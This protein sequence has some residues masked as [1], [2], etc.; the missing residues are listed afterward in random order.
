MW[1]VDLM[2]VVFAVKNKYCKKLHVLFLYYFYIFHCSRS[3]L[4]FDNSTGDNE[5]TKDMALQIGV[6][7]AA[8]YM[9][10][11]IYQ[12]FFEHALFTLCKIYH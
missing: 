8:L 11:S 10:F 4:G 1:M 12:D 6:V 5:M 2:L 7:G 9:V 3:D